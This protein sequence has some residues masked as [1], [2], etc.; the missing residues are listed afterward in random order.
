MMNKESKAFHKSRRK[1]FSKLIGRD[2][3]ALIFGNTLHNKSYDG[4]YQFKQYKNFYYLT[5]FTEPNSALMIAP[6]GIEI[7]SGGKK[8][9]ADEILFV[10]KKNPL[11]ET[12]NGRRLGY[13]N[14]AR[15]LG[16]NSAQENSLLAGF[17]NTR[18][19]DKFR[20]IYI[21]LSEMMKLTGELKGIANAFMNHLNVI[22]AH[23]EIIDT[24]Y[25]LGKMRAVKT[26]YEIKLM[27]E[28]ADITI[29]SYNN[30]LKV[31]KPGMNEVQI[32]ASLEYYYKLRGAESAYGP[33]VA[34]GE[35]ACT[36]HYEENDQSLKKGELLLIDSG[37]EHEYYCCDITRTVPVDGKFTKEQRL[38]YEIV[39]EANKECIRNMKPGKRLS[40][41]RKISDDVMAE[42]LRAAG[43]LKKNDDIK[44][45]SLHGVSHHIGLDT[46]D[47]VPYSRT[48]S[49]DNDLLKPGYVLTIEPGLYFPNNSKNIPKR[50]WGIGVRIEDDILITKNGNENLTRAMVKEADEIEEAMRQGRHRK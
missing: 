9:K 46:H 4:D 26:P 10:Q 37:A 39:L 31:I 5:G 36:L 41:L 42:G 29:D 34:G 19:L 28:S 38:I 44:K 43:L 23:V 1:E 35:N 30:T 17:L 14:V 13:T 49:D 3:A 6:G 27:K 15:E 21:N 45:Y 12:W 18:V 20:R 50:F 25:I 2:S 32:Q 8:K 48:D 11:M 33:I 7:E 24:S 40:R 16:I 47:A 22:A